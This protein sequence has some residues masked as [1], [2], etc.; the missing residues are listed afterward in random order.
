MMRVGF[1]GCVGCSVAALSWLKTGD[2]FGTREG[3]QRYICCCWGKR[4]DIDCAAMKGIVANALAEDIGGGDVTSAALMGE[5][6]TAKAA[7]VSRGEGVVAGLLVAEE[8]F[9]QVSAAVAFEP[10][11]SDGDRTKPGGRIARVAGPARALLAGE[12]LALNFLQRLSGIAT[13]TRQCVEIV[14]GYDCRILDTRKTTPGLRVLERY[15]VRVGGGANHRMG[16]Y[17]QVLIKDNHLRLLLAEVGSLKDAVTLAVKRA[18]EKAGCGMLVEVEAEDLS[19]VDAAL[20]AG[21]HIIML[22]NM[23][24]EAMRRAADLVRA[25]R[26]KAASAYPITEASGGVTL[27]VLARVAATGVDAISL[28]ALTHSAPVLDLAMEME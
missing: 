11:Q 9:R 18:L 10:V 3:S 23:A 8:V 2:S 19:M 14:R 22:D 1:K 4:V 20:K 26:R 16:L 27:D 12:R 28:G 6:V 21:A 17:D 7:I 15:A 25:F 13:L 24:E 5:D